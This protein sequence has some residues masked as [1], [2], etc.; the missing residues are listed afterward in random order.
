MGSTESGSLT[1][2]AFF[3][4]SSCS[5]VLSAWKIAATCSRGII[6]VSHI[7]LTLVS[8]FLKRLMSSGAAV[9]P[10]DLCHQV[11]AGCMTAVS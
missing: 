10:V 9:F 5:V 2:T 6:S 3:V 7:F 8:R 11:D 4:R 1:H